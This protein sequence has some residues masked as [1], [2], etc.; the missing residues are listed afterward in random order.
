[1]TSEYP[2]LL[3]DLLEIFEDIE[4]RSE[5][6]DM[7]IYWSDKYQ[8]A[9]ESVTGSK[10]YSDKNKVPACE[11]EA[12]VWSNARSDGSL[13]FHYVVENPQGLSAKALSAIL[14]TTVSGANLEEIKNLESDDIVRTLFGANVGMVRAQG[15]RGVVKMTRAYAMQS[16]KKKKT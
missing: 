16:L 7:L 8:R 10:P 14:S 3:Q 13:D 6:T 4:D 1:M 9:A 15:L 11:S 2:K 12:F 5:R